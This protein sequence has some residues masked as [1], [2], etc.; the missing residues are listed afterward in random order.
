MGAYD[1]VKY[2]CAERFEFS[3]YRKCITEYQKAEYK[4]ELAQNLMNVTQM[5]IFMAGFLICCC[6]A[7]YQVTI[8][9]L[10]VGKFMTLLTYMTQLQAPLNYFGSFYKDIQSSMISAE[11]LL[12]LFREQP[13]VVDSKDAKAIT[14]TTGDIE[15]KNVTFS[16][17]QRKHA[18]N[19]MSFHCKPGTITAL[20]GE[21]GG[22]KSTV[23][24]LLFRFYNTQFGSI[25]VD[26]EDVRDITINSLRNQIGVVPQ[27]PVLFHESI[28]YNL[29]YAKPG[30]SDEEIFK[31]CKAASIHDRI[32][33]FPKQYDTVVGD[34][35]I[36]LSGGEKQ[37]VAIARTILKGSPIILLDEATAAL[38]T[39]TEQ[40]IQKA[41][42]HLA[43]GRTMIVIAHRLSTIQMAD[44]ILVLHEGTVAE[45]GTHKEL[46][47]KRAR[48]ERM[49][50]KQ[51]E[52]QALDD[53][54]R[55]L[56][57]QASKLRRESKGDTSLERMSSESSSKGSD[58]D[59]KGRGK[60][61]R[62][63][64]GGQP[65]IGNGNGAGAGSPA[66]GASG[67]PR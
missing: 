26:G 25:E 46:R 52:A 61:G 22:G 2:F 23:F 32:M 54:A 3:R 36:R 53:D 7:A 13:T 27:E 43:K 37:R 33:G 39:E 64:I 15:F 34:R 35:G 30:C 9:K 18:L 10:H 29:R 38:D 1:T 63:E 67:E 14:G 49:W 56:R 31:A 28:M 5:A 24:R 51:S 4:V 41:L 48:Y 11:R 12:E 6:I 45:R 62:V 65:K 44:Q 40:N 60:K 50:T 57:K 20:V 66:T 42:K 21:S 17:E 59:D 55:Q 16:Y 19:G 8:G 47:S 58:E